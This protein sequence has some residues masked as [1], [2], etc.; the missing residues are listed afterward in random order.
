MLALVATGTAQ[1]VVQL[2]TF[3]ALW[4]TGYGRAILVKIGLLG[5]ALVLGAVNLLVT[6][7]RLARAGARDDPEGGG[8]GAALLRRTVSGEVVLVTSTVFAA[9][10][11]TSLP[12]PAAALGRA[13]DAVARVGPGPVR[14]H[15]VQAGTRA[16]VRLEPNTAVRPMDF[17]LDLSRAGRPLT[18]ATVIAKFD[19][20]DMDM[21]QEAYKLRET[22]P[23]QYRR[24]AMPLI[25]VGNWGV[26]YEVTPRAGAPYSFIV[27][28]RANG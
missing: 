27:V 25:M 28:D 10:V 16:I 19:M 24:N 4:E 13:G 15:V 6:T 12:P 20:L 7:P 9:S 17:G 2:P 22:G 1:T 14:H 3:G 11:L 18:G 23:G 21:G 8:R 26:T 5:G